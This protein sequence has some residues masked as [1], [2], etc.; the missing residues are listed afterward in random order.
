MKNELFRRFENRFKVKIKG[1]SVDRFLR[2]LI[3][4][5]VQFFD[6]HQPNYKEVN[7]VVN[8]KDLRKI[9][10][11]KTS[12]DISIVDTYGMVK[13]KSIL[14]TNYIIMLFS[15][16]GLAILIFL[17]NVIFSIEIIHANSK[18]RNLVS[19]ELSNHGLNIY[20]IRKSFK[21]L[22]KISEN[23][24]ND[25]KDKIEWLEIENIGTKYIVRIEERK[26]PNNQ[27]VYDKQ[28]VVSTKNAIIKS[29]DADKGEIVRQIDSYVNPGDIIISGN[30]TLNG[31]IK[32]SIAALGT[33]YGEVWYQTEVEYPFVYNERITTGKRNT[34]YTI[35]FLNFRWE[36]FNFKFYKEKNIKATT[37]FQSGLIPFMLLKE[38]QQ[39]VKIKTQFF[40]EDQAIL[41]A[42]KLAIEKMKLSLSKDEYIINSKKLKIEVKESKIVLDMFFSVY[43]NIT[44]YQKIVELVE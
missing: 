19:K 3:A 5:N 32:N 2:D 6:I 29:I 17:S 13:L 36:I 16:L 20:S 8:E 18:I 26:L 35:K 1:R 30:I 39:E 43:E 10:E 14:N 38:E 28:H 41:E 31:N 21:D 22:E 34:V 25:N 40:T 33:V 23:I 7:I 44:G 24:I 15:I 37:L 4:K 9:K 27:I 11:I 42:E 12:Y